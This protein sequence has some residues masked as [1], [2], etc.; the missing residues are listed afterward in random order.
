MQTSP[1]TF[2]MDRVLTHC[3]FYAFTVLQAADLATVLNVQ[4]TA[5]PDS[6][7]GT[8]QGMATSMLQIRDMLQPRLRP[9]PEPTRR[10]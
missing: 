6:G 10:R 5:A 1:C 8:A 4:F 7:R 9:S 3:T 2:I